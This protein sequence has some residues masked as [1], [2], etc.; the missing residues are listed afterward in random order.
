MMGNRG[1][2]TSTTGLGR[3][4]RRIMPGA[5]AAAFMRHA[6]PMTCRCSWR[7]GMQLHAGLALAGT[8][9]AR[10]LARW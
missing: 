7:P 9:L 6:V 4:R 5:I 8:V 10:A 2:R 1:A 3:F